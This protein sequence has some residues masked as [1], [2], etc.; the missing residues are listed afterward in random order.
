[1]SDQA[2]SIDVTCL[3]KSLFVFGIAEN[4]KKQFTQSPSPKASYFNHGESMLGK[5]NILT[6]FVQ[7]LR[8]IHSQ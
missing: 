8:V 1:M 4:L 6:D 2:A 5:Q 7:Y 3:D